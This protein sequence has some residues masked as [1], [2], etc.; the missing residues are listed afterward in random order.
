MDQL[1]ALPVRGESFLLRRGR[2]SVLV[3]G[4]WDGKS[5]AAALTSNASDL[6]KIDVVVCTHADADHARG[7]S[8]F[9][10]HWLAR[11]PSGNKILGRV[12]QFWLPGSWVDVLPDL[13]RDPVTFVN[14][15]VAALD[16]FAI[17][18][19]QVAERVG[20]AEDVAKEI[21]ALVHAE[22]QPVEQI[23]PRGDDVHLGWREEIDPFFGDQDIDLGPTEPSKEPKWFDELR[24]T[25]DLSETGRRE[26]KIFQLCRRRIL[27]RRSRKRI[28][29]ALAAFWL[30][31]VDT[32]SSIQIGRASC[33]E[34]V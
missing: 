21:D 20:V 17:K 24:H 14:G 10:D 4:G 28:G 8:T 6:R 1:L 30:G 2:F 29:T 33:R 13:M 22:R 11:G 3:D 15:L 31:L 18:Y 25:A 12:G 9:L 23:Q 16:A 5:L 27:Y 26:P 19:P 32:A 7:L 34:R